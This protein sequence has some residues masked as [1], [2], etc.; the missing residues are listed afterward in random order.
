MIWKQ[1]LRKIEITG[2]ADMKVTIHELRDIIKKELIL[3]EEARTW[4]HPAGGVKIVTRAGESYMERLGTTRINT[5]LTNLKAITPSPIG[6]YLVMGR[7]AAS[8][9]FVGAR[10]GVEGDPRFFPQ[11]QTVVNELA[12][13]K[14]YKALKNEFLAWSIIYER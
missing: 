6:E 4:L 1:G 13:Q 11:I 7:G 9:P 2:L 5:I 8:D 3:L 10:P 14:Q 12:N